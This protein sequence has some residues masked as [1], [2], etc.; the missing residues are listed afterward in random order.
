YVHRR[1][2]E[3]RD[4]G[5]AVL[6]ISAELDEAMQLADRIVVMYRGRLVGPYEQAD[7][8]REQVGLLMAGGDPA[9]INA[10]EAR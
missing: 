5:A 6:L 2:V 10:G 9:E 1:L 7:V 3:A 4:R 8:T